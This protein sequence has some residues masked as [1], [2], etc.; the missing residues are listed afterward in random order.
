MLAKRSR[1]SSLSSNSTVIETVEHV[2]AAV[3]GMGIDN[4]VLEVSDDEIPSTDGSV[5]PFVE[6]IGQAGIEEQ[7][8]QRRVFA[9]GEPVAVSEGDATLVAMG[10]PT[11]CLDILYDLDYGETA[12]VGRQVLGFR[13]GKDDFASQ[14]APA[15]TFL[16][17]AE[18]REFR[19]RGMGEHLTFAE[20]LVMGDDGPIDN[21]LRFPDEHVRHKI[22]D[23]IGDLALLGRRLS[24]RII[25]RKSGH[26]LNH[27]LI[28]RLREAI[29]AAE[30][31]GSLTAEPLMDIRKIMR[32]LP[33]RYPFL[34]IDRIVEI[35]GDRRAVGIKN[36]TVN[37]PYFQG[38]YPGQPVMPGVMI[39]EAMAQLSGVL[40][41]RRLEHTG[42]IGLLVSI[43]HV[44]FRRPAQPGDQLIIEAETIRVRPRTG[45]CRCRAMIGPD[46]AAEAEIKFMLVDAEPA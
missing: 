43:D 18:A 19:E 7:S 27:A 8:A 44:R 5:V 11:D 33:H 42:K 28:L 21:E 22:C 36:V 15:R 40:I 26:E 10:G 16:L 31:A 24:G 6:A 2:L 39:L 12:G 25:A 13:L 20:M 23:L 37:E 32:V 14:L 45:H 3:W 1:R 38:H 46:T 17:E 30:Q 4:I 41:T 34:M 29:A 35:D 9:I